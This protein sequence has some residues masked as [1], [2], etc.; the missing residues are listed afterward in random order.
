[1]S[2]ELTKSEKARMKAIFDQLYQDEEGNWH[3]IGEEE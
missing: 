3:R 2:R 1:M